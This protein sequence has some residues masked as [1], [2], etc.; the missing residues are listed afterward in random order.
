LK[1]EHLDKFAA[2]SHEKAYKAQEGGLFKDEIVPINV[3]VK[4]D[5]GNVKEVLID[6]DDGIRKETT[7]EG[8]GKLKPAFKKDGITTAGNSS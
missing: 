1:R 7:A 4:D 5:K 6:K 8:L 2:H 3:K